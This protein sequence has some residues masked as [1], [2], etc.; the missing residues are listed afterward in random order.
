[1]PNKDQRMTDRER[2]TRLATEVMGA[3]ESRSC[4]FWNMD[5]PE[6][7][8]LRSKLRALC[9]AELKRL[10]GSINHGKRGKT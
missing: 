2:A 5:A 6:V 9:H 3:V 1:M 4:A 7:K 8:K 10:R